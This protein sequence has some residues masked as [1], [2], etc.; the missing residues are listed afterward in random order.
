MYLKTT[1]IGSKI[2]FYNLDLLLLQKFEWPSDLYKERG[3]I[4]VIPTWKLGLV[5]LT[6]R[7]KLMFGQRLETVTL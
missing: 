4:K 1:H 6:V 5:Y 2:Y 7:A 3:F